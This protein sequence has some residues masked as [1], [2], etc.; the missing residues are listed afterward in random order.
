MA[1]TIPGAA[2]PD[3]EMRISEK[4]PWLPLAPPP[5]T[6]QLAGQRA[7]WRSCPCVPLETEN[8]MAADGAAMRFTAGKQRPKDKCTAR[9][10]AT[11]LVVRRRLLVIGQ[12]CN[13]RVRRVDAEVGTKASRSFK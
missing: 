2:T 9:R 12:K 13:E 10:L 4:N 11:D 3:P 1:G 7:S 8:N 5:K 6:P